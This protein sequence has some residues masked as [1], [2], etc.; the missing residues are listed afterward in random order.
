MDDGHI[1]T[2]NWIS[3]GRENCRTDAD[4]QGRMGS[5]RLLSLE[6]APRPCSVLEMP[7]QGPGTA[8]GRQSASLLLGWPWP[9]QGAP[10]QES[11]P[12]VSFT[13]GPCCS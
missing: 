9:A 13:L 6:S 8:P 4:W 10:V 11:G 3:P 12:Q 1:V 2:G 5:A 7:S